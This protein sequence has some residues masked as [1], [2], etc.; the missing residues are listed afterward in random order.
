M[1]PS[2]IKV[3]A[4]QSNNS[5]VLAK[6]LVSKIRGGYDPRAKQLLPKVVYRHITSQRVL[7]VKQPR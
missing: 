3:T 1:W 6:P 5:D 4:S 2:S 7:G